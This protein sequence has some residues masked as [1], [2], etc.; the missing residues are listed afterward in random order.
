MS[1]TGNP[2]SVNMHER[3]VW[4]NEKAGMDVSDRER[5]NK[6]VYE[7]SKDSAHF[8]EQGSPTSCSYMYHCVLHVSIYGCVYVCICV[9]KYLSMLYL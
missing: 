1:E 8:K 7:M 6:I 2:E 5:I 3:V 9:C 4:C